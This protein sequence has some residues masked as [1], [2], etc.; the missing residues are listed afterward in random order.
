MTI[1]V[2]TTTLLPRADG[3]ATFIHAGTSIIASVSGPM[4]VRPRDELPERAFVEVLVRP[5]VGVAGTKER[6]LESRLSAALTP[7]IHTTHHPRT[8][9]QLNFQI[10]TTASPATLLSACINAGTL[11]LVDSGCPL[12]GL[13]V[14]TTVYLNADGN[15]VTKDAGRGG[16]SHVLAFMGDNLV[17]VESQG[18]F[19]E[20]QLEGA[21]VQGKWECR[22]ENEN[23]EDVG[24]DGTEKRVGEVVREAVDRKIKRD[25]R[26]SE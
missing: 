21:V 10:I 5:C 11:A 1:P 23:G 13:L 7:L 15:V 2:A 8:L 12:K 3:S 19:E 9:I 22:V 17:F 4:E 24:M 14:A 26:W 6:A 20:S 25:M 18:R 16:S